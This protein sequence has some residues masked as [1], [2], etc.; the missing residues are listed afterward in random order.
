[1]TTSFSVFIHQQVGG[2]FKDESSGSSRDLLSSLGDRPTFATSNMLVSANVSKNDEDFVCN[3]LTNTL[4][5]GTELNSTIYLVDATKTNDR[6]SD[7]AKA[8]FCNKYY[9][10]LAHYDCSNSDIEIV[11]INQ[12]LPSIPYTCGNMVYDDDP[13]RSAAVDNFLCSYLEK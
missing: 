4:R 2:I 8:A 3:L 7:F 6:S 1:M 13:N 5:S 12:T 10:V 11:H 9:Y